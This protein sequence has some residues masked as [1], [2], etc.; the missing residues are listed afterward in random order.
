MQTFEYAILAYGA[1]ALA[2]QTGSERGKG[3]FLKGFAQIYGPAT[4]V[5]ILKYYHAVGP[6]KFIDTAD[7]KGGIRAE[8][9]DG[10]PASED[11]VGD[12]THAEAA[13]ALAHHLS[14]DP[15]WI[16]RMR[17]YNGGFP[18]WR[19]KLAALTSRES[20]EIDWQAFAV[21]QMQRRLQE[22]SK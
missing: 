22:E 14:G 10:S 19:K 16:E 3:A 5:P 8:L 13:I 6:W 20:T 15:A 9:S 7:E 12:A 21:A 1:C 17:F 4:K 2:I 11:V 18:T